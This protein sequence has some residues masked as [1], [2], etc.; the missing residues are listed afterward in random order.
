M[1][2][3]RSTD[4][5]EH[6]PACPAGYP[7]TAAEHQ[8]A[9]ESWHGSGADPTR[10]ELG[11]DQLC[12]Y[13]M[14]TTVER[15]FGLVLDFDIVE[16]KVLWENGPSADAVRATLDQA[17]FIDWPHLR[18]ILTS[19][20]FRAYATRLTAA[21]HPAATDRIEPA[22]VMAT[23]SAIAAPDGYG[24]VDRAVARLVDTGRMSRTVQTTHQYGAPDTTVEQELLRP[25]IKAYEM[26]FADGPAA[27][28]IAAVLICDGTDPFTAFDM[29]ALV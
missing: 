23:L 11:A 5:S 18:R 27:A 7:A 2:D 1:S 21:R 17:G 10:F 6:D 12:A 4:V 28:E 25:V 3:M 26:L 20:R 9:V 13:R 29:A 19:M 22:A 15:T 14:S 8:A 24:P 16:R